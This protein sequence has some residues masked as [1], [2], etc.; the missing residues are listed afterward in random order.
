M[1]TDS[2]CGLLGLLDERPDHVH[3]VRVLPA[4]LQR[5]FEVDAVEPEH[6]S[7]RVADAADLADDE[8]LERKAVARALERDAVADLPAG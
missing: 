2:P 1:F 7:A 6:R 8:E 3:R 5:L 4:R